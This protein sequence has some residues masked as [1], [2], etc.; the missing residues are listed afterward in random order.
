MYF[1]LVSRIA[2]PLTADSMARVW[3]CT[4]LALFAS[5]NWLIPKRA[6]KHTIETPSSEK[7]SKRHSPDSCETCQRIISGARANEA[8]VSINVPNVFRRN[9]ELDSSTGP[10]CQRDAH[11]AQA[12]NGKVHKRSRKVPVG[13]GLMLCRYWASAAQTVTNKR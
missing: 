3:V 5:R 11:I 10:G 1:P 13:A 7:R 9:C 12:R 6:A 2:I 8:L 4:S